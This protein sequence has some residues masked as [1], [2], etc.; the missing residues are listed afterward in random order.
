MQHLR[1]SKNLSGV[2]WRLLQK[3]QFQ[4]KSHQDLKVITSI[5]WDFPYRFNLFCRRYESKPSDIEETM[6]DIETFHEL[7]DHHDHDIKGD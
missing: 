6:L 1:R 5:W 2:I 7:N 3:L 4:I